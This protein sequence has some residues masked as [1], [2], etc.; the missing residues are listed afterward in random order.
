MATKPAASSKA[1]NDKKVRNLA[2]CLFNY[3][4]YIF[5]IG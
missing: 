2:V 4:E 1:R 3:I 5:A